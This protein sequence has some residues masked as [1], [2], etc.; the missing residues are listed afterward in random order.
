MNLDKLEPLSAR[1]SSWVSTETA[2]TRSTTGAVVA[3]SITG[4]YPSLSKVASSW[5][6]MGTLL[7]V[8]AVKSTEPVLAARRVAQPMPTS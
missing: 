5:P 2:V 6:A 1:R 8:A 3:T 4:R 7:V